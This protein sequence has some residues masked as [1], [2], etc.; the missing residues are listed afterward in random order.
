MVT[1]ELGGGCLQIDVIAVIRAYVKRN[2]ASAPLPALSGHSSIY[3][4]TGAGCEAGF[5]AI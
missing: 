4:N 2:A 5:W 3:D 1:I